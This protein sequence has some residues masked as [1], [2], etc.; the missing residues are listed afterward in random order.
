MGLTKNTEA[1]TDKQ[2]S[3]SPRELDSD[4]N[5]G[6]RRK[7]APPAD[8]L[9]YAPELNPVESIWAYWKQHDLPMSARRTMGS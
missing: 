2:D 8:G 4:V 9:P 5:L 7:L 6:E 3:G 1:Q